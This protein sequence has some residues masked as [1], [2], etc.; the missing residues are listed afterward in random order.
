MVSF[1]AA[2]QKLYGSFK[3]DVFGWR[4]LP[5]FMRAMSDTL[6]KFQVRLHSVDNKGCLDRVVGLPFGS[7]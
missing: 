7:N 3:G 4:V 5:F 6:A 2:I 1:L